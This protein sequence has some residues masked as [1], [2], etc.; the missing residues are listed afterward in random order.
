M[1]IVINLNEFLLLLN[2]KQLPN[3]SFK[4]LPLAVKGFAMTAAEM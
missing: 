1:K 3:S 2:F 4:V